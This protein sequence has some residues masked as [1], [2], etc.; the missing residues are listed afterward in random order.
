[1]RD[2]VGSRLDE[3][4]AT[5]AQR[6]AEAQLSPERA[7]ELKRRAWPGAT[8]PDARARALPPG[9]ACRRASPAGMAVLAQALRLCVAADA[10]GLDH[11]SGPPAGRSD[12]RAE[13]LQHRL[14][15]VA[16]RAGHRGLCRSVR[17][18]EDAVVWHR[19]DDPHRAGR[20]RLLV[21][22][23]PLMGDA[24]SRAHARLRLGPSGPDL[25]SRRQRQF[26]PRAQSG[27]AAFH[28]LVQAYAT[29]Q[30]TL[31]LGLVQAGAVVAH[32]NVQPV[33][34][35]QGAQPHIVA[36][37]LA[38]V[39]QQGAQHFFQIGHGT[40]EGQPGGHV[41]PE[42]DAAAGVHAGHQP[43]QRCGGGGHLAAL[44]VV[45]RQAGGQIA[46]DAGAHART[47][48]VQRTPPVAAVALWLGGPHAQRRL[49]CMGEVFR[50]AARTRHHALVVVE[51]GVQFIGQRCD[52]QIK[53]AAV[54]TFG[55]ATPDALKLLAQSAQRAQPE[56][57]LA[58]QHRQPRGHQHRQRNRGALAERGNIG[59]QC[60]AVVGHHGNIGLRRTGQAHLLHA[61]TQ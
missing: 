5:Y 22:A 45:H 23:P 54:D 27:A 12:L 18:E 55:F 3:L 28:P 53:L 25:V 43:A 29:L 38:G 59:I 8:G 51:Q 57:D 47:L 33:L 39:V 31:Q 6:V 60:A 1:M 30:H 20:D 35:G 36:G 21:D 34:L 2:Y 7:Q 40:G 17:A 13:P 11:R 16:H 50:T 44:P 61:G 49:Q 58:G 41:H 10:A 52:F 48:F 15:P 19:V 24:L 37:P 26:Q 32:F 4:R 46:V 9:P 14:P 42:V 56:M